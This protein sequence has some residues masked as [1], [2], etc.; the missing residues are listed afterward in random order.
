MTKNDVR[1]ICFYLPQFYPIP[2]NDIAWGKGYTEWRRVVQAK[3]LFEGHY[4]PRL[5]ADLGF[6][7]LRLNETQIE[8]AELAKKYGIT[9]FCYYMYWFGD[10]RRLLE[11]PLNNMV[12]SGEPDFPYCICW[13]NPPWFANWVGRD[14]CL[15]K[16]E[17]SEQSA[18]D[19]MQELIP[20]FKDK[21]YILVDGKPLFIV[22]VSQALPDPKRYAEIWRKAAQEAGFEDIYLC[23]VENDVVCDPKS[24]GFDAA[25]E[26]P[27]SGIKSATV[28]TIAVDPNNA[29]GTVYDYE[30]TAFY[31]V[32][33]KTP[34]Y[35]LHRG[36]FP[37]WD[38]SARRPAKVATI[39]HGSTPE[40]YSNW[41]TA[42]IDWTR[43]NHQ[44]DERIVFI[45][46]WNEWGESAYLE[47]D[48][49][50]GHA[51]LEATQRAMNSEPTKQDHSISITN[52]KFNKKEL[53]DVAG[54]K[55]QTSKKIVGSVDQIWKAVDKLCVAG[56]SCD[57]DEP[58]NP[59]QILLYE[60][61]RLLAA[62]RTF[63]S[64]P[65]VAQSVNAQA[66]RAGFHIEL[67]SSAVNKATSLQVLVVSQKA[68]YNALAL[69]KNSLAA[70]N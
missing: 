68:R 43:E 34:S 20:M 10:G 8:Q 54:K 18:A 57:L 16:Q 51:Y 70:I 23:R 64:R 27:P 66:G 3:P 26:I 44:G 19:L 15:V 48:L 17:Y 56:W 67:N 41:L 47:P 24:I 52:Y 30:Q 60:D 28:P 61:D 69:N 1:L 45:N 32:N 13:A 7:D 39:F 35:K 6:Y 42:T 29:P 4:Q 63:I 14:D 9:G 25:V 46:A 37:A 58:S 40:A 50:F 65:D 5:P 62:E 59:V 11:R 2:E 12:E 53:S 22:Y 49:K 36:V 38:N 33:K 55:L 31:A 21:R